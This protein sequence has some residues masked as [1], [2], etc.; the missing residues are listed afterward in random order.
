MDSADFSGIWKSTFGYTSSVHPGEFTFEHYSRIHRKGN[1]L[2]IES[3]PG[4]ES[5]RLTR[6]VL[7]G[8]VAT[9]TWEQHNTAEGK[10]EGI[11]YHGAIQL[12]L[13]ED[14]KA[15]RGLWIGFDRNMKVKSGPWEITYVG[16]GLPEGAEISKMTHSPSS[17]DR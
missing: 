8:R 13:D 16:A 9:G 7:D 17:D 6:V 12:I 15:M 3:L 5:Y 1:T 14:G 4:S 2:V 10:H 11:I